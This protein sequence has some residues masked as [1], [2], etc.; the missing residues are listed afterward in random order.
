MIPCGTSLRIRG[1]PECTPRPIRVRS[2]SSLI[3]SVPPVI[4]TC[5]MNTTDTSTTMGQPAGQPPPPQRRLRRT[6]GPIGGVAAGLARFFGIDVAIVRVAIVCSVVLGGFGLAAYLAAWILLPDDTD[7][8]PRPVAFNQGLFRIIVGAIFVAGAVSAVA[9]SLRL[10]VNLDISTLAAITMVGAGFYLLNQRPERA[11]ATTTPPTTTPPPSTQQ[12]STPQPSTPQPLATWPP[13]APPEHPVRSASTTE[14]RPDLGPLF[15]PPL[16]A[17]AIAATTTEDDSDEAG[18]G[19]GVYSGWASDTTPHWA[20]PRLDDDQTVAPAKPKPRR[21][22]VTSVTLA[23]AALVVGVLAV[24]DELTDLDITAAT[25]FGASAIVIGVGVVASFF[26]GRAL[27]LI[28]LGLLALAGMVVAPAVDATLSG[29]FGERRYVITDVANLD[30]EYQVGA[31]SIDL[32]LRDLT[33]TG[34]RTITV[35]VGAG[36][37]E[38]RVP[39]DV[40]VVVTATSRFGHV[41]V[42]GTFQEGVGNRLS[43]T[44]PGTADAPTLTIESDVT[45]GYTEIRR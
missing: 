15:G 2:T 34:D 6:D 45:F 20:T 27:P 13:P 18:A 26:I 23:A 8:D 30:D 22:P 28:P 37:S 12:P 35:D 38:I 33:L 29:G 36:Y 43:I 25:Y 14:P 44:E 31:G 42:L 24:L 21:P 1:Y 32:D 5:S 9:G 11:N 4:D 17:D 39:A 40:R 7:T 19:P 41:D 10:G 16:P 3:G